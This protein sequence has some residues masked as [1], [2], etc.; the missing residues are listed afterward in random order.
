LKKKGLDE[1]EKGDD[2][3]LRGLGKEMGER[4]FRLRKDGG[5]VLGIIENDDRE[6]SV[7]IR[8]E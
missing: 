7:K 1:L 5:K 2:S 3:N 6:K 4:D 8:L